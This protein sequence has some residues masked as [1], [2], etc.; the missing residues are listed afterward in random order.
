M[1]IDC[2]LIPQ[3]AVDRDPGDGRTL[4][5]AFSRLQVHRLYRQ[6]GASL[7]QAQ[8]EFQTAFVNK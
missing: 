8:R 6:T 3:H 2:S 1:T 4:T 5:C 7:E